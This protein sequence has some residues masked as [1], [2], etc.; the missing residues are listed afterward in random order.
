[1]RV[2]KVREEF[3][4]LRKWIYLNTASQGLIPK[5]TFK[6]LLEPIS[7][8]ERGELL[9]V[10]LEEKIPMDARRQVAKLI[11]AHPDEIALMTST[12]P[13]LKVALLMINLTEKD[14]ILSFDLEFPGVSSVIE[15]YARFKGCK[16]RVVKHRNGFYLPEDLEKKISE[17]TKVIVS[18]SVQWVNG[19]K[20]DLKFLREIADKCGAYLILDSIQ[21]VGSIYFNVNDAKPDF[22]AVGGEKWLLSPWIGVGFLYVSRSILNELD[23]PCY[24]LINRDSPPEGWEKYW[25]KI[26]K[27]TWKLSSPCSKASKLE[28]GGTPP[29]APISAFAESVRLLNEI[30]IEK[31]HCHNLKLKE[32]LVEELVEH[33]ATIVSY[34]ED[35]DSWSSITTFRFHRD[36]EKDLIIAR[37]LREKGI[38]V[39]VRGCSNIGGIRVSPHFY[40]TEEDIENLV[41]GL[42]KLR[43]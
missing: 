20:M 42:R 22:V 9:D 6:K 3:P 38:V 13:G 17:R 8:Q 11:G 21:H 12:I 4:V 25:L 33:G 5:R 15:S 18:S 41:E 39:S 7:V 30:G 32:K 31:I 27:E 24:G 14:E 2:E 34:T 19:L 40:N 36:F 10:H 43:P 16:V 29:I 1:M 28:W 26:D 35:K 23:F 37:K